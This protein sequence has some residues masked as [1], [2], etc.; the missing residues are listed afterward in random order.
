MSTPPHVDDWNASDV[1]RAL[2]KTGLLARIS[3][4]SAKGL[5]RRAL[6]DAGAKPVAGSEQ[7]RLHNIASGL[8]DRLGVGAVDL[9]VIDQ[10]GPNALAGR[11]ERPCVALT[12][13]L[14]DTYA[15]TELEAV[16]AHCLVR[17]RDAG[18]RATKIGY[19]DDVRAVALTRY[20][21]ALA[22]ALEKAEPYPGRFASFYMVA[23]GPSHRPVPERIEALTDL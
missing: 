17:F 8:A 5:T 21:P 19:S 10:G 2:P 15:R 3:L 23:E 4:S 11:T 12:R 1:D 22:A 7:P 20:P 14:L 16:V 9:F 13:S 18:R 6:K